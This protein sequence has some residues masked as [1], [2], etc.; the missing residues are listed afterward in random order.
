MRNSFADFSRSIAVSVSGIQ[1]E[2]RTLDGTLTTIRDMHSNCQQNHMVFVTDNGDLV[3]LDVRDLNCGPALLKSAVNTR[4]VSTTELHH[5]GENT[6]KPKDPI[7]AE[8]FI[9]DYGVQIN[10]LVPEPHSR[11]SA[12]LSAQRRPQNLHSLALT[13][14]NCV[15]CNWN[16]PA[17]TWV[18]I[19]AEHGMLR[20]L[21]FERD[22]FF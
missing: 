13:R 14:S 16:S 22:K 1:F 11:K 10:P 20:I 6:P 15:R 7:S 19:G 17:H 5:L 8:E 9:R 21:N 18:A 12:Y 2:H 3:F 4:A